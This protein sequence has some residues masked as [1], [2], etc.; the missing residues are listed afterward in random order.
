MRERGDGE[1]GEK[2]R[3]GETGGEMRERGDGAGGAPVGGGGRKR[4]IERG[5]AR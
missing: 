3:D 2:E 1:G 4:K 5:G